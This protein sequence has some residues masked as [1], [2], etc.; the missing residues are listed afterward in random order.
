MVSNKVSNGILGQCFLLARHWQQWQFG[1][2][3]WPSKTKSTIPL[4]VAPQTDSTFVSFKWRVGYEIAC[5]FAWYYHRCVSQIKFGDLNSSFAAISLLSFLF[6]Y[7]NLKHLGGI[8]AHFRISK[9]GCSLRFQ[10]HKKADLSLLNP[11]EAFM[12]SLLRGG[13]SC[14]LVAVDSKMEIW[15]CPVREEEKWW[16]HSLHFSI[17][18]WFG[19]YL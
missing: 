12:S 4:I 8:L 6:F 14:L 1:Q 13:S 15:R 7:L 17:S 10:D 18:K 5:F 16:K 19:V 2:Q 3:M 11:W 9:N